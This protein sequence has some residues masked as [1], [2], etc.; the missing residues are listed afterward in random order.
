M[1]CGPR[2]AG[3]TCRRIEG[4]SSDIRLTSLTKSYGAVVAVAGFR[5]DTA[6]DEGV[7]ETG[8]RWHEELLSNEGFVARHPTGF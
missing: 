2:P 5:F 3:I 8:P 1:S 4:S 6:G 7:D